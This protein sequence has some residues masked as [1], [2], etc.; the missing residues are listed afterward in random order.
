MNLRTRFASY[1]TLIVFAVL[2]AA[3]LFFYYS[4]KAEILHQI[5]IQQRQALG[6]LVKVCEEALLTNEDIALLNYLRE[7]VR[8]KE[9]ASAD[10]VDN[11]GI[12]LAHPDPAQIGK[13]I[14]PEPANP[15]LYVGPVT[16]RASQVGQARIA[17]N[18]DLLQAQIS[19]ALAKSV[20]RFLQSVVLGSLLLG[21]LV[22]WLAAA[23]LTSPIRLLADGARRIGQGKLDHRIPSGRADELGQLASEFN[24]MAVRL[25]EL[26]RMKE[27]FMHSIT[28]DLRNPL[29][30]VMGYADLLLMNKKALTEAQVKAIQIIRQSSEEL[31]GMISEILDLAKFEAGM[32]KLKRA[33]ADLCEIARDIHQMFLAAAGQ[34]G[35]ELKIELRLEK[36]PVFVDVQLVKRVSQNFVS[37]ALKFTPHGG[38]V[39]LELEGQAGRE[40][41]CAVKD[42]GP[43][44][45]PEHMKLMFQKFSQVPGVEAVGAERGTGIGLALSKQVV[46]AHGGKI[47]V[48]SQVGK[49]SRFYFT[50]PARTPSHGRETPP[51]AQ[52]QARK[53]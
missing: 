1:F 11:S 39:T 33:E 47:G 43:G 38:A 35:I 8:R 25:G 49:G 12:I 20:K 27:E 5:R 37:N 41:C 4:Q 29:N 53:A 34:R 6:S 18:P 46:E 31:N 17:F 42:T 3:S 45:P 22:G 14:E 10:M 36:A 28:H 50:L 48:E 26:D 30:S 44:I 19:S 32:M 23:G 51:P 24:Q 21:L 9:V 2:S 52:P 40:Y 7:L 15:Y 13:K 16:V